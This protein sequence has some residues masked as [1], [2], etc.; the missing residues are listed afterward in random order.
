M[1]D[2]EEFAVEHANDIAPEFVGILMGKEPGLD[3]RTFDPF[4]ELLFELL[5]GFGLKGVEVLLFELFSRCIEVLADSIARIQRSLGMRVQC[6]IELCCL[7]EPGNANGQ[8]GFAV[9]E[10]AIDFACRLDTRFPF[11]ESTDSVGNLILG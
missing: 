9:D 10:A 5:L 8:F 7:L 11:Q 6:G 3:V 4:P 2:A 1:L